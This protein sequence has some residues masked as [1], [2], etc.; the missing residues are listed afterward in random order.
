MKNPRV[1]IDLTK[2]E[3]NADKIVM[4]AE[5]KGLKVWG[6]S[7][8][9]NADLEVAKAMLAG[10]VVGLADSR[11]YNLKKLSDLGVPL[12]LLRTP[13]ITEV[14]EV[15]SLT[16]ISLNS[17]LEVIK[18][19]NQAAQRVDKIHKIILMIDL[20]DRREGVLSKDVIPMVKQIKRLNSI[21]LVGLGT[22]LACFRGVLPNQDNMT[23]LITLVHNIRE[24]FNLKLEI[25]SGGNSSSLPLLLKNEYT[26]L[27]NQ[28]RIGETILLGREVPSGKKFSLTSLD[29]FKLVA[30][31]IEVKEKP[32]ARTGEEGKN[33]FGET[34]TINDK[35]IRKRG[36]LAVGRQD[37]ITEGLISLDPRVKI[38]GASSDHLIVDLSEIKDIQVGDQLSFRLNYGSLL[39]A[40]TSEHI[41]KIY[42]KEE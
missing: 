1:E 10:G 2:I 40:M 7:K 6:V 37:I 38:E 23:K 5:Q 22:N 31:L 36:I 18:K 12:M 20:G 30:E 19:L 25:I 34:P 17:E 9:T 21:K 8:G 41:R 4:L 29:T 14:E 24:T 3:N 16:E 33:A 35:G 27:T 11:I 26:P 39:Q 42:Q 32:T 15:V 13:M 28:L